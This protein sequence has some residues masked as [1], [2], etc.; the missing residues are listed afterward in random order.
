MVDRRL[1]FLIHKTPV[2]PLVSSLPLSLSFRLPSSSSVIYIYPRRAESWGPFAL[3]F[4]LRVMEY[5]DGFL[6]VI[7]GAV[8]R[9]H[10][11]EVCPSA[12]AQDSTNLKRSPSGTL[13]SGVSLI[14][15]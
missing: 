3:S 13:W 1:L 2:V 11:V 6:E 7:S 4:L 15:G 12:L 14:S 5:D 9:K 10:I 8:A